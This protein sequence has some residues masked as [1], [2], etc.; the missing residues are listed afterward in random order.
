L[1]AK[2]SIDYARAAYSTEA[3]DH[4]DMAEWCITG[5]IE[6]VGHKPQQQAAAEPAGG[7]SKG[8]HFREGT[9][10]VVLCRVH[11]EGFRHVQAP[12]R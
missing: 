1:E 4:L 10:P 8:S 11:S 2:K 9:G 3:R 5:A 12:R 7:E 6:E